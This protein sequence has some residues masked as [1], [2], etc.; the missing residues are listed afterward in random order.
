M[1]TTGPRASATEALSLTEHVVLG[2]VVEATTHGFAISKEL[3]SGTDLG[4]ILTVSRPLVYRALDRLGDL[5]LI[6]I[7][8]REAG[9]AGPQRTAYRSTALG[10]QVTS[11][12]LDTP[13]DH[14]R[15]LRQGFLIKMRLLDR[16]GRDATTLVM[17]QMAALGATL[18]RLEGSVESRV[19]G[20]TNDVVDR[21]RRHNARSVRAFL[22][23]LVE[24]MT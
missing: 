14:I 8:T 21:W 11:S 2:L 12:W 20:G 5:G 16:R 15:D 9:S 19:G 10:R 24:E 7:A 23:D 6:E 18:S 17:A 13:V 3:R 4:R 22:M 1:M